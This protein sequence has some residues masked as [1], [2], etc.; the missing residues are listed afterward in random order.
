MSEKKEQMAVPVVAW[1]DSIAAGGWPLVMEHTYNCFC[2]TGTPIRVVN[3]GFGGKPAAYARRE[4]VKS[5][6][7]HQPAVVFIQFGFNDVRF[8]GSR[9]SR[10]ISTPDEF[11][12]H[13]SE[14]IRLCREESGAQ[15]IVFGNHRSFVPLMLPSGLPYDESVRAYNRVA[16][17]VTA[18]AKVRFVDMS[19]AL[20]YPG[21]NYRH[22]L[23]DDGLHLSEFGKQCYA[24]VAAS[25]LA[26]LPVAAWRRPGHAP[27]MLQSLEV[28]ALMTD[29]KPIS[30]VRYPASKKCFTAL[31]HDVPR[32]F[33]DIR[34]CYEGS[35]RDGRVYAR[36]YVVAT[37]TG[38]GSLIVGADGPF[39]VFINGSE[40]SCQPEATNP[41]TE[42]V[43][44]LDATWRKGR[45]EVVIAMRTN[46]GKAWG[47]MAQARE[48]NRSANSTN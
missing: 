31:V 12:E 10:P 37:R 7:I 18:A 4:F 26:R 15:V 46:G 25:E 34:P 29:A 24:R 21:I 1:G 42:H 20:V 32:G 40:V 41:I 27:S 2:N 30:K 48:G 35:P 19:K 45:N 8:D 43:V 39:K 13:L 44:F 16:A 47:F 23:A 22:L 3:S 5:V 38:G 17:R 9:G 14:M 28:S 11:G 6:M 36:G 33:E